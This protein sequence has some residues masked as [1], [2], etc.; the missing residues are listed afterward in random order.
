MNPQITALLFA[1]GTLASTGIGG[2]LA[3]R[4]RDRLRILL[5]F[6]AGAIMGAVFFDL[7]PAVF[8]YPEIARRA[9]L[10]TAV[11][12]LSF[13]V[14]ERYTALHKAREHQSAAQEH[15]CE[16]GTLAAAGLSLHSFLDGIAIGVGFNA[17]F[18]VGVAIAMAIILHDM[19]DGLNT[20]AVVLAHGN[21]LRR[22]VVW[23][24]ID[25][26]AP[27]VGV[28]STLLF[29]LPTA[30]IPWLLAFFSGFFLYMGASDLLPAARESSSPMVAVATIGG[31]LLVLLV[32]QLLPT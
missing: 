11:G 27:I 6:S 26:V 12:F 22:S 21:P 17:S 24:A 18:S 14:L 19:S 10:A 20:V 29:H 15:T 1:V 28:A 5:G 30:V 31:M 13:F 9:M 16:L 2:L 7:L 8:S 3:I 32:S 25:M 23:L 4:Y